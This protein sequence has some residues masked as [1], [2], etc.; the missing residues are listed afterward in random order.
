MVGDGVNDAPALVAADVGMAIGSGTDT[1]IEA[2]DF[3]LMRDNIEDVLT[4]VDLAVK[5]FRR[6]QLNFLWAFAY[7]VMMIPIAAG[8]LYPEFQFQLPPWIAGVAMA[9]SSVSVVCSSLA[10]KRYRRPQ[11]P[12]AES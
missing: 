11:S 12:G 10:L 1:A 8:A 4:A 6:I 5:T 3:V 9:L 2:A 7:N